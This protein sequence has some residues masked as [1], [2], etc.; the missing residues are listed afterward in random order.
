MCLLKANS[1]KVLHPAKTEILNYHC[2]E[3]KE[4]LRGLL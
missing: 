1:T 3:K 4:N 2:S